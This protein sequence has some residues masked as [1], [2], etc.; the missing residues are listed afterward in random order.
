MDQTLQRAPEA[1]SLRIP[2]WDD[3]GQAE[4][5]AGVLVAL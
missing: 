3:Y 5:F 1:R 2:L 4:R